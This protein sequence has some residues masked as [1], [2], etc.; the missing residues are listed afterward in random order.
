MSRCVTRPLQAQPEFDFMYFM[1]VC[2]ET[3]IDHATMEQLEK[4]WHDWKDR[5]HAIKLTPSTAKNE[6]GFLLVHLT[7][8]VEE[9]VEKAWEQSPSAGMF[10]H[11][12]AITLV[13]SAVQNLIPEVMQHCIPLPRPGQEVLASFQEMGLEWNEQTGSLNRQYAAYTPMPYRGGCAVCIQS[14]T[15]PKSTF[16]G[17]TR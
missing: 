2:G 4:S 17:Q 7:P 12:L 3:R 16:T 14:H 6:E 1:E 5:L 10:F 8:F 9:A 13:M 15:C 11:N